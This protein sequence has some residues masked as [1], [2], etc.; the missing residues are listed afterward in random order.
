MH[1]QL[2]HGPNENSPDKKP[3]SEEEASSQHAFPN[4][5]ALTLPHAAPITG[6]TPVR[7]HHAL[8]QQFHID[9]QTIKLP[10]SEVFDCALLYRLPPFGTSAKLTNPYRIQ[11]RAKDLQVEAK[12]IELL[13]RARDNSGSTDDA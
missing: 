12:L 7:R 8:T 10:D 1:P 6:D 4:L 13:H 2:P 3:S 5:S 9:Y 11:M